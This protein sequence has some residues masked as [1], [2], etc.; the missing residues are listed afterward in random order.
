MR[1]PVRH[2]HERRAP[3][4]GT[5]TAAPL[6]PA[7]VRFAPSVHTAAELMAER[8]QHSPATGAA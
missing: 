6:E 2:H 8:G 1:L 4:A 5:N 7:T 3:K